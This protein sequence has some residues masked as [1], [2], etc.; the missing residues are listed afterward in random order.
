MTD[1]LAAHRDR[2]DAAL[3]AIRTRGYHSAFPESP[4]PRV[5]GENAA[6]DGQAAFEAHLGQEYA[7]GTPGA[8]G[9]VVT[10][11]SPFGIEL[12]VAYPRTV[13]DGLDELLTAARA[14][15]TGWRDAGI[16]GRTGVVLEILDRLHKRVFELANAVQ[17]TSGQ[18]FVMAFQAGGAHALDRALEAVAYAHEEMSRYPAEALWEKP[19]KGEPIR[20]QKTFTVTGRGVALV[21]GCNTFPTWN[22][23]PGLFASLVTGN[24]VV[25][26]PHPL[27]VLPLAITVDV[28]REVLTEAGFDPNLVT[29]AVERAGDGL[30]K[31]LAT[32]PEVKLIDFTGG[33]EFGDWLEQNAT[34]AT[35]FTE[36]AGVNAVIIDSTDAFKALCGN[37]AFTL[38]LYSGQMCTTTQNI[39]VPAGGIE[40]DEGHKTFEEVGAGIAGALGKLLGDDARAV[41]ILGGIVNQA[42]VNRLELAAQYGEVVLESRAITH[43]AFP[44]AVVRTPLLVAIDAQETDVYGSECF[45]PVSFLVKTADTAEAIEIFG[46]TVTAGGAMT[47]GIYS[48]DAKVLDQAREAALDAGVALSEN[49]TG[50]VFVNQSAAF[51]DFHGTG[52]NPAANATYTDGAYVASRFRVIQSRRHV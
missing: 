40:T 17:H 44:N 22:S 11:E 8:R 35:V 41:E 29:L 48:T 12:N 23:W 34:Q 38:A 30:A 52:A 46:R 45:G 7:A 31:P 3:T 39:F 16:D 49:L 42:V 32:R 10:E 21:I 43:P 14:G 5:Y 50:P 26:K 18:A 9:T 36:K 1:L 4:S 13:E 15:L 6:A 19:A 27:A 51:S 20:M 28:C 2:L 47:A 33:T 24:A 37:L 25:V